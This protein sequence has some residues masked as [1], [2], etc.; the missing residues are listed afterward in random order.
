M[1]NYLIDAY[2]VLFGFKTN[3][4]IIEYIESEKI[5]L[6]IDNPNYNNEN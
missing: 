6:L 4:I 5:K 3:D 1:T 2:N